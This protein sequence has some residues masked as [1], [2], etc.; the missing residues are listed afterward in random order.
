MSPFVFV[1]DRQGLS[2]PGASHD[3]STFSPIELVF[4]PLFGTFYFPQMAHVRATVPFERYIKWWLTAVRSWKYNLR[5]REITFVLRRLLNRSFSA[6]SITKMLSRPVLVFAFSYIC[7][8]WGVGPRVI[9]PVELVSRPLARWQCHECFILLIQIRLKKGSE[10]SF[11]ALQFPFKYRFRPHARGLSLHWYAQCFVAKAKM[12]GSE[13]I[14][15]HGHAN[16]EYTTV[17]NST[18]LNMLQCH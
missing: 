5:S 16:L 13:R 7:M 10:P 17:A 9:G 15:C 6:V 14:L 2:L 3:T 4:Y 1:L 8:S 18:S 11:Y 12:L